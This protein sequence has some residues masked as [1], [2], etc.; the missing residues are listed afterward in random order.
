MDGSMTSANVTV[1]DV[2]AVTAVTETPVQET[3]TGSAA[4]ENET[5]EAGSPQ[6]T[7]EDGQQSQGQRRG[8]TK[9]D[10]IRDLR[11][12]RR[13]ARQREAG[14]QSELSAVRQQLE[15]LRQM[16]QPNN[17]KTARDPSKFW[18]D[19]QAA[20]QADLEERLG[21]L[22]ERLLD[23]ISM[24]REMEAQQ[25]VMQQKQESAVEFIRSQPNYAPEDD[26]DLIDII[27]SI[28]LQQRQTL[29]PEW[30]AEWAWLKLNQSRGVG[31]RSRSRARASSVTGQPP[32]AGLSGKI[33]NKAEFDATVD[34]LDKQGAKA[35]QKLLD[36]LMSAAKEG[37]V[38]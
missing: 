34:M 16:Q 9:V 6:G 27:E 33:W 21:G 11:A 19:P 10:E 7:P 24:S 29:D 13:E 36:E 32:G 8:W 5:P 4:P 17:G 15:E 23:R 26:E 35:D 20:I 12:W 31:D 38:R 2:P 22:E 30:V 1:S 18:Q 28:P 14:Y 37:R 3:G 25:Q